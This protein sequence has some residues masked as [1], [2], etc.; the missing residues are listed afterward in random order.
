MINKATNTPRPHAMM[1]S[2]LILSSSSEFMN[3]KQTIP[4][5]CQVIP[6]SYPFYLLYHILS[7]EKK[8]LV[9]I[10]NINNGQLQI[11]YQ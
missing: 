5:S 9:I 7:E 11:F 10:Q 1:I 2:I 8:Q 6:T 3:Q 4:L